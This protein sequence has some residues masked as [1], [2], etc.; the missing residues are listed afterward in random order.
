MALNN[1]LDSGVT[2]EAVQALDGSRRDG[3]SK[4]YS[5]RTIVGSTHTSQVGHPHL[6]SSAC[7]T[8]SDPTPAAQSLGPGARG[9]GASHSPLH[10]QLLETHRQYL[11][12]S[13]RLNKYMPD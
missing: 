13:W 11:V 7:P 6:S 12:T 9:G 3:L 8:L 5:G 10:F 1:L 4:G 2:L